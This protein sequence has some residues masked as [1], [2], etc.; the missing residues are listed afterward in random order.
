MG[1]G[2]RRRPRRTSDSRICENSLHRVRQLVGIRQ[3]QRNLPHLRRGKLLIEAGHACE[4]NT[5]CD[6]P[7][8]LAGLIVGLIAPWLIRYVSE[9]FAYLQL[10]GW[11]AQWIGFAAFVFVPMHEMWFSNGT[12]DIP[13]E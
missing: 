10:L 13:I 8:R 3:Q 7:I 1:F 6:L 11:S 4:P 5:I 9:G 12:A 2:F